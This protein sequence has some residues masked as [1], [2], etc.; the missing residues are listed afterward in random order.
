MTYKGRTYSP[1][2]IESIGQPLSSPIIKDGK[3]AELAVPLSLARLTAIDKQ[4][5]HNNH[6]LGAEAWTRAKS[7]RLNWLA[8]E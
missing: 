1:L 8:H 6:H 7:K 3:F 5:F 2:V 4:I